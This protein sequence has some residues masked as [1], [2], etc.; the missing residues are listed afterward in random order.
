MLIAYQNT[1]APM[2]C[3]T[4]SERIVDRTTFD[5]RLGGGFKLVE[6]HMKMDWISSLVSLLP[7]VSKFGVFNADIGVIFQNLNLID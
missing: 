5:V 7:N 1:M 3:E 2:N 6:T 4:S